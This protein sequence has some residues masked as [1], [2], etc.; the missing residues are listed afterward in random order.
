MGAQCELIWWKLKH[1]PKRCYRL[2]HV[3]Y[4]VR[5]TLSL[6]I[7]IDLRFLDLSLQ[8]VRFDPSCY[9]VRHF[10]S[11]VAK[12]LCVVEIGM[13]AGVKSN[14]APGGY[15]TIQ[16][17]DMVKLSQDMP[18]ISQTV[19]GRDGFTGDRLY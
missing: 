19:G 5:V 16:N 11:G 12:E 2:I 13:D 17:A 10:R 9:S 6:Q 18:I 1:I 15:V 7:D 4:R 8:K 14:N 3:L